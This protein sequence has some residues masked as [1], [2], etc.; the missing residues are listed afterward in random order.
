M[1]IIAKSADQLCILRFFS[2]QKIYSWQRNS[3]QGPHGP[4][5][6]PAGKWI[7]AIISFSKAKIKEKK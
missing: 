6:S 5:H 1:K 7:F 4:H 3:V 2:V